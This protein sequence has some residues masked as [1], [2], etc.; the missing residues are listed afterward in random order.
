[1][2]PA[3]PNEIRERTI[4]QWLSGDTRAKIASDNSIGEGSVTNIVSDFNKG[5]ADSEFGSIREFVVESRKHG[6]TLSNL[7][8]SLRLYNHITKL[9]ANQEQIESLVINLV[10][11]PEPEKMI[12]VE[13]QVAQLSRSK[14]IPLE[15]LENHVKQEEEEKKRL[16]EEIKQRR[17]TLESTN[18]EIQTTNE[19]TQL[20]ARLSK[21]HLSSED[22]KKLVTVLDNIKHYR[23]D[24]KKI[25]AVFS[26]VKSLKRR[27]KALQD[28][29]EILEKRI[30]EDRQVLPLLEQI[31]SMEIGIDKL[32]T[33][34]VAVSEKA[35]KYNLSISAAAYR[36]IEDLENY[37]RIGDMQNEI[38]S[39]AIQRYAINQMSASRDKAITALLKLQYYGISDEEVLNVYEY[40]NRA[41][42]SH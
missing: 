37:N 31:R 27:E 42:I 29:C 33:F 22:P 35:Q 14:S 26:N 28:N 24:P 36:I 39:L 32:L 20:K 23:Y 15:D 1:M 41:R 13:N 6:L 7:G 4:K 40:L 12:D 38:A 25:V 16:E 2:P 21:Y 5:L 17:S 3:I 30:S 34:C 8:P 18:V 19:Y 11:S 10:T 9:G